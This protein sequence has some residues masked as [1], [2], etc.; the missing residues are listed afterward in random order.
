MSKIIFILIVIETII[1]TV[2]G[3]VFLFIFREK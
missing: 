2:G 1:T 3:I